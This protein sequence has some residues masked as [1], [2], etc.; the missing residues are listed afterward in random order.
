MKIKNMFYFGGFLFILNGLLVLLGVDLP[1]RD[2]TVIDN[3]LV[4]G[5]HTMLLGIGILIITYAVSYFWSW[6]KSKNLK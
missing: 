4:Y 6:K 2:G 5:Q 1:K 3:P